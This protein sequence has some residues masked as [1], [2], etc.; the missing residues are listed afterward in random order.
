MPYED[1]LVCP[2]CQN[3]FCLLEDG[4]Y[5]RLHGSDSLKALWAFAHASANEQRVAYVKKE[6]VLHSVLHEARIRLGL[7]EKAKPVK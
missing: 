4:R 6:A 1:S 5:V 3:N 7:D 2:H